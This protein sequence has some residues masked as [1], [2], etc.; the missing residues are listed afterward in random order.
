MNIYLKFTFLLFLS[1][2]LSAE[3]S[4]QALS[5]K[6]LKPIIQV[7]RT[8]DIYRSSLPVYNEYR[9]KIGKPPLSY[10]DLSP[11]FSKTAELT[12]HAYIDAFSS[13]FSTEELLFLNK[14]FSTTLGQEIFSSLTRSITSGKVQKPDLSGFDQKYK[15]EFNKVAS[16][17]IELTK[18]F[19]QKVQKINLEVQQEVQKKMMMFPEL[20]AL[21]NK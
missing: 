21:I 5:A 18:E 3:E 14:L 13:S 19:S 16:E 8:G 15:L 12:E 10:N 2:N 9:Q 17:N 7:L 11:L 6:L 20:K 1:F 4:N